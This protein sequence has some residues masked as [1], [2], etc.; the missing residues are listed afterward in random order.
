MGRKPKERKYVKPTDGR[1]NN[2]RKRGEKV[3]K[4]ITATPSALNKAKKSRVHIYA[5][6]AMKE[7]FGSEE[8][9]WESLAEKAKD[10]FPHLKLLFEYKYGKPED[11][12]LNE[13]KPKVNI[14]IKNLFAGNQEDDNPDIIDVTEE[15]DRGGE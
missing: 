8:K 4:P 9:A 3:N 5:L 2:G 13:G 12:G 10:S 7:V 14:N 6:N 1:K 15:D 11:V